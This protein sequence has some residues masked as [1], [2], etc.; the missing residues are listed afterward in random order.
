[1]AGQRPS[2]LQDIADRVHRNGYVLV[3]NLC[4]DQNTIDLGRSIGAVVDVGMLML[5]SGVPTVQTLRPRH[6]SESSSNRYSG[7]Y[8]LAEFPLHTDLAHWARP[9]RYF[10]LRCKIGSRAVTTRLLPYSALNSML[11]ADV[12]R[13][14]VARPRHTPQSGIR[15]L[16][17]FV[18]PT[19]YGFGFRWDPLFLVPMNTSAQRLAEGM[20][21]NAWDQTK[22][23]TLILMNSG[24]TLVVDNWRFLHGRSRVPATDVSRRIERVYL[25]EFHK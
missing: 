16:L 22:L 8:G 19:G 17:P 2:E 9:P 21:T 7:T 1:M 20:S 11:E 13:R 10:V 12:I 24:D 4:P 25:S 18:F 14:A 15:C 6:E 3:R 5:R 23:I